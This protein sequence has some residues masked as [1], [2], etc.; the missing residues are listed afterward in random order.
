L[1]F[2]PHQSFEKTWAMRMAPARSAAA[3]EKAA[4]YARI[5]AD[6]PRSRCCSLSRPDAM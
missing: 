2:F 5:C 1:Q 3:E 4:L 6:L